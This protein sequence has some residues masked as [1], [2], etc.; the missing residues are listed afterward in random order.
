MNFSQIH[1]TGRGNCSNR[2]WSGRFFLSFVLLPYL[3]PI[4]TLSEDQQNTAATDTGGA[5][6]NLILCVQAKVGYSAL[7]TLCIDSF[8]LHICVYSSF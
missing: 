2:P 4:T 6:L 5:S 3:L 7:D 1:P 8:A